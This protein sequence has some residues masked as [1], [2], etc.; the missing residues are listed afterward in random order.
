MKSRKPSKASKKSQRADRSR[1]SLRGTLRSFETLEERRLLAVAPWSDGMFYPPIGVST[2]LLPPS[3]S[4]AEYSAISAQQYGSQ[5]GGGSRSMSGEG[6]QPFINTM[7]VEPNNV[8][9][10]A[11]FVNLGTLASQ[12]DGVAITANLTAPT[13]PGQPYVRDTDWFAFDLRAGDVFDARIN[14]P[15][16]AT[17]DLSILDVNRREVAGNTGPTLPAYPIDSPL[18]VGGFNPNVDLAFVAPATGRYYARVSNGD[19]AYTL[20]MRVRRPE[21]ELQPVGTK[22]KLFLD[23]DGEMIRRDIFDPATPG[24]ARLSPLVDFLPG[25]GL[26]EADENRVIDKI[27]QVFK[28]KFFGTNAISG[29]GGNGWYTSTGVAGQFDLEILNS[30]DHA[31]PFGQPNVSRIIIGGTT[32]ELA[33][34]TIGIAQSIDVG[35][36]ATE[37][38][39]VVLLD[40]I[41]PTWGPTPRAGNVPLED[42]LVTAI[43]AVTAHEAGHFFGAWHTLNNNTAHQIMDT[44][45]TI[46]G[47]NNLIG[48]GADGIF[49]TADDEFI[50]FGTDVYDFSAGYIEFGRQNSAATLA[51]GLST[52]TVGGAT[53]RGNVYQDTNSNRVRDNGDVS[54]A[55]V[56]IY[57]DAN[58]NG[59]L[60]SGET[61]TY[62]DA[63]GNYQLTVPAG[64]YTLRERV[65]AGQK[66]VSP[67]NN[68]LVVTV[69]NNQTVS[70]KDFIN[71]KVTPVANG[72]KWNDL[73]GN[74]IRDTGEP[75]IEGVYIYIDLDGDE[76]IDIGEPTAKTDIN[77]NYKLNFP[78]P[79]TYTV[80]EVIAPG[81][82]QTLPG[83][84]ASFAYVV[85]LTGNPTTDAAALS[86]LH[87]GNQIALDH[88]DAPLSYGAA[89]AGFKP[90]LTLGT[91][92]D[93]EPTQ[94]YSA[95]A[96]GD[97]NDGIADEDAIDPA[98]MRPFI[99][100]SANNPIS[101]T[102]TNTTGQTAY[103]QAWIDFDGNGIFDAS[104]R[105]INDMPVN[106]SALP[107]LNLDIPNTAKAGN[108]FAR[109]RLST[110]RGVGPTG[111]S[112]DGEVEDY[113]VSLLPTA[114]FAV[115]D[116]VTVRRNSVLN[117]ID[118]LA[119]D[120]KIGN[121]VLTVTGVGNA[122]HGSVDF[123]ATG[124]LYTPEPGYIGPD[125]FTYRMQNSRG[126]SYT[127]SV[128][129]TVALFF[130]NPMALDDSFD[131]P[132]NAID[133]PLNVLANDIE[134][135]SGALSIVSV[136]QPNRG[137]SLSI[138]SGSKALRYTPSR[139]F[140]GTEFF[141]YTVADAS[142]KT[143]QARGTLHT[144]PG[145]RADDKV[146]IRLI[147]TDLA[148]NPISRIQQG[149]KFKI[150]MVVDDLRFDRDN[151]SP[152]LSAGVFAAYTDLLYNLQLVGVVPAD[153]ATP[154]GFNFAVS[155]SNNYINGQTGDAAIP[156]IIDELGAFYDGSSM[157]RPDPVRLASITFEAKTPGIARFMA[158]PADV[159]PASNS[160]LFDTSA[161]A[162]PIEEIRYLGT[163][164][165]IVGDGV[166]F[167]V[168]IDDS[169]I[170]AVPVNAVQFPINVLA[171][172]LPG[173]SAPIGLKPGGLGVPLN[174]TVVI[175]GTRVL[176]TPRLGFTGT[177]QFTYTLV[178]TAGNES[179]GRVT[180]RVGNNTAADDIVKLPLQV[181][182]LNGTPITQ[183]AVGQQFQL[184]GYVQDLRTVAD[185]GV[186]AAYQDVIYSSTLASPVRSTTNP[187]G[188]E[189][190][191]G[192]KY[193]RVLEGD[194]LTPG[195]FNELGA[196]ATTNDDADYGN[197][198]HLLF[199][200]TMTANALGTVTF[201][202]DPADVSPRHDTL[203]F[204]P[205][206]PVPISQIGYGLTSVA[207]V[208]VTTLGG[209]GGEYTNNASPLDV[210]ADGFISPIDV[211]AVINALNTG[212]ARSLFDGAGEGE[213]ADRFYIDT[214]GDGM[215]SP[216]DALN[217]INH[218]NANSQGRQ[219]EGEGNSSR[220]SFAASDAVY[221]DDLFDDGVDDLVAQLA[222][223]IEQTWKKD[224]R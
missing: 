54:L 176:Y 102:T 200:I 141:T 48:V 187:L 156:G 87:F 195:L 170:D 119:N 83:A 81:F 101:I 78:G 223:D 26:T 129:V 126:E 79:G 194:I 158:D 7:E 98:T 92:W 97:D 132:T 36:F 125:T 122:A 152:D 85:T 108:T 183:V 99:I 210:N 215:L 63:S 218:L 124:V 206:S 110:A 49:G 24:T 189:I 166:V 219:A 220:S 56:L 84:L 52:G 186:F 151:T 111:H 20:T 100:G 128:F 174:G 4:V 139:D 181:T 222:P 197:D 184:R 121:E 18:N 203:M 204:V 65:P 164:I 10:Q 136:T 212:G 130:D 112:V 15:L 38:S 70:G 107:V 163:S 41:N 191:F 34:T 172:D 199:T 190:T 157:N 39:A 161:T 51:F 71:E 193:Q 23:F 61:H 167:P 30:R 168:A 135:N 178:D 59:V 196:V 105:V 148:G 80:R 104:E 149:Q 177:D 72:F 208:G 185:A 76:R 58:N 175:S 115:N 91:K 159:T 221:S 116:T 145:D 67:A 44:G 75:G 216:M 117:T 16:A 13:I 114:D 57:V 113:A 209:A 74:G 33:I 14:G 53:I 162:V 155:F 143:S 182:N 146:E 95:D 173:S 35:N 192:P 9:S 40:L 21:L 180:L 47:L 201:V 69:G 11:N 31:D 28:T 150:D 37:E 50:P 153:G 62:S 137:G 127:A 17:F 68:A 142:G 77:G 131:V 160:L 134:G 88:G 103:L 169:V 118:V 198:N 6:Q 138:A 109:L 154:S 8:Y 144:L 27:I 25:W 165:E 29:T 12:S 1:K 55:S 3:L 120:F 45:G 207:I 123:T 211:L 106:G 90:G 64:T 82:T 94:L 217:V 86:A 19:S 213:G 46:Q 42:V 205:V 179:I 22:Q 5:Q 214:N 147:A 188:F 96:L 32:N 2:A 202:G 43:G 171:N 140:G 133:F 66:L 89:S 224:R 60:D 73:N 93:A